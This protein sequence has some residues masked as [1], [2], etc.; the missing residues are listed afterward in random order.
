MTKEIELKVRLS[1]ANLPALTDFLNQVAT[2][3]DHSTLKNDYY[4]TP[5]CALSKAKAA[6][7]IRHTEGGVEQ[8]LKTRGQPQAGLQ[9]RGEWNWPLSSPALDVSLLEQAEVQNA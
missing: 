4:D 7:R 9:I 5:A 2:P 3:A 1:E 8:T 6:L